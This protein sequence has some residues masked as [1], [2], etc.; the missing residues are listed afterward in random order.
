ML[1]SGLRFHVAGG[2]NARDPAAAA[3]RSALLVREGLTASSAA[4][5]RRSS[6]LGVG[7]L[8]LP[9][10]GTRDA[11]ADAAY[12]RAGAPPPP[13][14]PPPPPL[15]SARPPREGAADA[16]GSRVDLSLS[17]TDATLAAAAADAVRQA[18]AR[19]AARAARR[20]DRVFGGASAAAAAAAP[21][22]AAPTGFSRFASAEDEAAAS[23]TATAKRSGGVRADRSGCAAAT[24]KAASDATRREAEAVRALAL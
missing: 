5:L 24:A 14:P 1:A 16:D 8:D 11:M 23:A 9:S 20:P 12:G 6:V 17:R 22:L 3:A 10:S 2:H 19:R 18:A 7:R 4:R 21:L 15:A 13:P